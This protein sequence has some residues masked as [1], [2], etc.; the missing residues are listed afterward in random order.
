MRRL[1]RSL[2]EVFRFHPGDLAERFPRVEDAEGELGEVL[3]VL[4]GCAY[5]AIGRS[6]KGPHAVDP[7]AP[8]EEPSD[9]TSDPSIVRGVAKLPVLAG[10]ADQALLL[11]V[12]HD[13]GGDAGL[14]GQP[15][16][17]HELVFPM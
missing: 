3:L 16:D 11:P 14:L 2:R 6:A 5:L 8:L 9:E 4:G 12:P 13:P 15:W 1:G 7:H 10:G 17:R